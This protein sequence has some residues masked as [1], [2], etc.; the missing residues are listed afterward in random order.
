M[1]IWPNSTV[2][3]PGWSPTNIVRMVLIVG[4]SRSWGQKLG[5]Q[6]AIFKNLLVWKYEAQ[7]FHIWC[8]TS[9]KGPLPI[10]GGQHKWSFVNGSTVTFDLFPHLS[11]PGPYGPSCFFRT[12]NAY[13]VIGTLLNELEKHLH[14]QY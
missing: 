2:M 4:I 1:G 6:T 13:N 12:L 14:S 10:F 3:I 9:S 7:R 11:D 5:F 8:I